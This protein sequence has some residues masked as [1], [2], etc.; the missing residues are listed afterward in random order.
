MNEIVATHCRGK[1]VE[2]N[3]QCLEQGVM[4]DVEMVAAG[5]KMRPDKLR[6]WKVSFLT[7]AAIIAGCA[8]GPDYKKPATETPN[9]FSAKD[10]DYAAQAP[11]AQF[12][13]VFND[14]TLNALVGYALQRNHDVRI[15]LANLNQARAIRNETQFDLLPSVT[16]Q[17]AHTK[18]RISAD[19]SLTG[20]PLSTSLNTG[21]IDAVWE[22]DLWG[23]VRREVESSGAREQAVAA[24]LH[25]A[26]VS[27]AAE[28]ARNYFELRGAQEQYAV[29]QRNA[30]NQRE[31][32]KIAEARLD[33][34][35]G[36]EFDTAR[37]QAQLNTTLATLPALQATIIN[38]MHR[39][40]VL[41]GEQ[42]NALNAL[43][44]PKVDLPALPRLV[45]IGKPED[46]LRRR[47]DVA[48][49]ER[50][51]AAATADI[52][53]AKGEWFPRVSFTGEVGF[54]ASD[55]DR[56][57]DGSRATYAYGP[58]IH[59][60]ALDFGHVNAR[61]NQ[62]KAREQGV[63]AAYEQTVLRAL[64]E[65]ENALVSYRETRKQLDYLQISAQAS[66]RATQLAHL[67][68][69]SGS[70][71]FL[72]VLDVERTQL[73]TDANFA[74]ARTNAATSL[75]ALYKALGGGWEV[76]ERT[77]ARR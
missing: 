13:T 14:D 37:A 33:A 58:S 25:A 16:A 55:F 8:V 30:D 31:T 66:A 3:D 52:G 54:A 65:T 62:A 77:A 21:S 51:L 68:F 41:V 67:R 2:Q 36:T 75:I 34:G 45:N 15:A 4:P 50:R 7:L 48:A 74:R 39:L 64:E 9:A 11:L 1:C 38:T 18:A 12:W 23:R 59:W 19:Q 29:A 57:G 56:I 35:R 28:V 70:S 73:E 40:S 71:N 32:L 5:V 63:L 27:V 60:A 61:V 53:V 42:P 10:T 20:Q 26:Q 72:D 44:A 46:L 69:D 43:L 17:A 76:A 22:L 24:D 6:L 49:A 47:P